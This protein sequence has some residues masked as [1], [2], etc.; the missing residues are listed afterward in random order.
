MI[1]I[2]ATSN[3][4][5]INQILQDILDE[6][7][8]V[9][10]ELLIK[11]LEGLK[12]YKPLNSLYYYVYGSV[13]YHECRYEEALGIV[14]NKEN[15]WHPSQYAPLIIDIMVNCFIK[16]GDSFKA[17][18][19]FYLKT[20]IEGNLTKSEEFKD[21]DNELYTLQE[22]F[23]SGA[24]KK[25]NFTRLLELYTSRWRF[26]E[27]IL[28]YQYMEINNIESHFSYDIRTFVDAFRMFE[29]NLGYFQEQLI[30]FKGKNF[31][32]CVEDTFSVTDY[33]V[34]IKMLKACGCSVILINEAIACDLEYEI[35]IEDTVEISLDNLEEYDN[36]KLIRPIEVY[37]N[38]EYK[39]NN[40]ADI[41]K[42]LFNLDYSNYYNV[43][44]TR[45]VF[46]GLAK[47][48]TL[49]Q[50]IQCLSPPRGN[51]SLKTMAFGYVGDY[52]QYLDRIYGTAYLESMNQRDE[53]E[54]SIIIPTRNVAGTLQ[55]TIQT[56]LDQRNISKE[57][58][59]IIISDNSTDDNLD[60]YNLV[61]QINDDRIKYFKA[62]RNL[63]LN[64]SFEFA[65]SKAR[66]NFIIPIGADDG[67]LSWGLEYLRKLIK[68]HPNEKIITWH[69][70]F[71]QWTESANNPNA[72]KL[73]IP[74]I[75]KKDELP[76]TRHNS[77]D[78][79]IGVLVN[80]EKYMYYLPTLYI[81]SGFKRAYLLDVY[82]ETGRLWDGYTQ[83]MYITLVN[84][85]I[86]KTVIVVEV[87]L[88]IAGMSDSSLGAKSIRS[89]KDNKEFIMLNRE[90]S[91]VNGFGVP[92]VNSYQ[93]ESCGIDISLI[94]A[95][96]FRILEG[97]DKNGSL[98][99]LAE[100]IDWS[101]P[102]KK[103]FEKLNPINSDYFT[104]LNILR[105]DAYKISTALGTWFERECYSIG[106][107]RLFVDNAKDT[108]NETDTGFSKGFINNALHLDARDFN[109]YDVNEAAK[110]IE[111][112]LN[113]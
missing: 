11:E 4:K 113:L 17:K 28:V 72:G 105:D 62:P 82:R 57:D 111:R 27:A 25:L 18:M 35:N 80:P 74:G 16:M 8:K 46:D 109:V 56:C 54:F 104:K 24:M 50:N 70:A 103:I 29:T 3:R 64:R 106:Q 34:M 110:L 26:L 58:Y 41:L 92:I 86:N 9:D 14:S 90:F 100:T 95:E 67:I 5:K 75:Y 49:K 71:F 59:E 101:I 98:A 55:A 39:G 40:I 51:L 79:I 23:L 88:T 52:F 13:L 89:V 94:V 2:K 36:Y 1:N 6:I 38:G 65:F 20:V 47:T 37:F 19:Y 22:L 96:F 60:V 53:V 93:I 66:G 33:Q 45:N 73:I 97:V 85:L 61:Q 63:P 44:T 91:N 30:S 102:F 69:R 68:E 81:N 42:T 21:E 112:I 84:L 83:D 32:V 78:A 15:W 87:P 12:K 10:S 77:F 48:Q 43:L 107:E 99:K 76:V 31:I 108:P 7:G